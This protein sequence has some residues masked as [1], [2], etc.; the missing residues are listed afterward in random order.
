MDFLLWT[1]RSLHLFAIVVWIGGLLF[2]AAV[3]IPVAR[4]EKTDVSS[5]T[6]HCHRRFIPF[7]WMSLWTVLVTGIAL[8]LFN[9]RYVFFSYEDW[10]SFVLA[11]KQV[12]FVGM[13]VVSLGQVRM[14]R[15]AD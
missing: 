1:V 5:F 10:W 6:L 13:A 8:M 7:L 15:R 9:P 14:F 11:L 3:V 4:A 12:V 2:Q